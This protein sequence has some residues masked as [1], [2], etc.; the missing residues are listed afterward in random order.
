M[1]SPGFNAEIIGGARR[2]TDY[3]ESE[4]ARKDQAME[5]A[6]RVTAFKMKNQMQKEI[7]AGSPG[8]RRMT[9]LSY[10]ARRLHGRSP[11]RKPLRALASQVRYDV[12]EQQPFT[13]AVGF[14]SPSR[15][16]H[17]L[18]KSW[19]RIVKQHQKGFE[20]D[21]P[22]RL[23]NWIIARGGILGKAEGGK[24]PFFL[25]K[26]TQRFKTPARPIVEP[27]WQYHRNAAKAE[28]KSNFKKKM[29][30]KRI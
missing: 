15:G 6:V 3:I 18:S 13:M 1:S 23:R 12:I 7:R 5:T 10:I 27:F 22:L 26:N 21:I 11:N 30:G 29:A 4:I 28:I 16:S 25:K 19:Q 8:H 17:S 14:I 24:T 20:R 9:P 2:V